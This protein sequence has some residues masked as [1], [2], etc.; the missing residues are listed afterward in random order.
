MSLSVFLFPLF[1][2]LFLKSISK[3]KEYRKSSIFNYILLKEKQ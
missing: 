1:F 2:S 3:Q